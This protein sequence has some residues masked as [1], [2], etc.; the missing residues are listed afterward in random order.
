LSSHQQLQLAQGVQIALTSEKES[1][2]ATVPTHDLVT[3]L[4][5]LHNHAIVIGRT[6][7]EELER[8]LTTMVAKLKANLNESSNSL[9]T[10]LDAMGHW[11]KK[12]TKSP[13]RSAR[14]KRRPTLDGMGH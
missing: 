8:N 11:L 10:T 5:E 13:R 14:R 7:G 1:I 4:V 2:L 12:C 3:E 9:N 6:L